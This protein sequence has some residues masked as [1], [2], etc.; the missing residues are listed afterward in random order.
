MKHQIQFSGGAPAIAISLSKGEACK[1]IESLTS[2][3]RATPKKM[4]WEQR[5]PGTCPWGWARV[6]ACPQASHAVRTYVASFSFSDWLGFEAA[7]AYGRR[8]ATKAEVPRPATLCLQT[9]LKKWL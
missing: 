4:F 6:S 2:F 1:H 7:Y 3:Q 9:A 8:S 5:A